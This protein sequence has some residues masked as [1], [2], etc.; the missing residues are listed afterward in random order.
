MISL[1]L[2]YRDK[3]Y[4]EEGLRPAFEYLQ[5]ASE[6][7]S[8]EAMN[9]LGGMYYD[10]RANG[11]PD[12]EAAAYW[13]QKSAEGGNV[14]AWINLGLLYGRGEGVQQDDALAFEWLL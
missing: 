9:E 11:A 1:S 10:G 3:K 14:R 4:G 6:M 8:A 2:E 7:G 5:R 13:Y 12:Y